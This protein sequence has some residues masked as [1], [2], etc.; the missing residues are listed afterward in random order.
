MLPKTE[1]KYLKNNNW[2]KII[3]N[4]IVNNEKLIIQYI[5]GNGVWLINLL[6]NQT[7]GIKGKWDLKASVKFSFKLKNKNLGPMKNSYCHKFQNEIH[8][9]KALRF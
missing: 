6:K 3:M 9:K 5:P 8:Q 2:W 1:V 4:Y 7:K